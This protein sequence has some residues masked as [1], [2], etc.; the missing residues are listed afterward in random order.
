MCFLVNAPI[1][2]VTGLFQSMFAND[3]T[4]ST[5]MHLRQMWCKQLTHVFGKE[6]TKVL[7]LKNKHS[8]EFLN[9]RYMFN[10]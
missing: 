9:V 7:N 5:S 6:R 3:C 2:L 4:W 1:T 8:K 10:F